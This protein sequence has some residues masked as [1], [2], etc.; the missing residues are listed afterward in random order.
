MLPFLHAIIRIHQP[1]FLLA[2]VR[3]LIYT[4]SSTLHTP[5][6]GEYYLPH[7]LTSNPNELWSTAN[8]IQVVTMTTGKDMQ[9]GGSYLLDKEDEEVGV[10]NG[11]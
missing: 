3:C 4:E 11:S 9:L 6:A 1:A 5:G 8:V 10:L 2:P 7:V